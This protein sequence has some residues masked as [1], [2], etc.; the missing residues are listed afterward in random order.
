MLLGASILPD[1]IEVEEV[2]GDAGAFVAKFEILAF[3]KRMR[4]SNRI[5][6]EFIARGKPYS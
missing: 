5:S 4:V 2:E 3:Q 1:A 6:Q